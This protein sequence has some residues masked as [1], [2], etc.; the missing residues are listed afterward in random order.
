MLHVG[1]NV[2]VL[3]PE[4]SQFVVVKIRNLLGKGHH[5]LPVSCQFDFSRIILNIYKFVFFNETVKKQKKVS[6][7][8]LVRRE[9][10]RKNVK[11]GE[12]GGASQFSR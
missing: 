5:S 12:C 9:I 10:L 4:K 3:S 7:E 6:G 2:N 8:K 11:T 1:L